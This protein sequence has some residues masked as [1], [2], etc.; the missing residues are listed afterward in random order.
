MTVKSPFK[1]AYGSTQSHSVTS[2]SSSKTIDKSAKSV[3]VVN[4]GAAAAYFRIG[5]SPQTAS[6]VDC[7]LGAG[8]SIIVEK[9]VG[10]DTFAAYS[11]TSTTL[12]IGTGEG[13]FV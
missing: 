13:G 4:T 10:A 11:A 1:P 3:R 2:T 8:S 9:A 5:E 12:V 7:Y 6:A